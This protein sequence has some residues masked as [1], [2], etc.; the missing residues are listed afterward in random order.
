V[1]EWKE[2]YEDGT[3][4]KTISEAAGELLKQLQSQ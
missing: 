3:R 4:K 1:G 2:Y